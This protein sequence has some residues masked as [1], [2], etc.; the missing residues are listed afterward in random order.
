[1]LVEKWIREGDLGCLVE[2]KEP[3]PAPSNLLRPIQSPGRGAA[4]TLTKGLSLCVYYLVESSKGERVVDWLIGIDFRPWMG[5][6]ST[7]SSLE[8]CVRRGKPWNYSADTLH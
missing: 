7:I 4:R 2:P 6:K 8:A 3:F 1:M 5:I